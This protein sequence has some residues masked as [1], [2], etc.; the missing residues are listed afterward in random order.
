MNKNKIIALL[1]S[2]AMVATMTGTASTLAYNRNKHNNN[3]KN[4]V[5]LMNHAQTESTGYACVVNGNNNLVLTNSKGNIT[6]YLS[7][8]EMLHI[9]SVTGNKVYV[10]VKETG[11]KGYINSSNILNI[12]NANTSNITRMNRKG[13]IVNVSSTV[14]LRKGPGMD[15][16]VQDGLINNT[17]IRITGKV[18]QW[19]RV[20][21]NGQKGYIFE[22]YVAQA[23]QPS[24]P[25]INHAEI[26]PNQPLSQINP[27]NVGIISK[28]NNG[29]PN[30]TS[31]H[32]QS[33]PVIN[34][35]ELQPNVQGKP[36]TNHGELQ[37][38]VQ[39]KPV[40]NHGEL[41]P[42]VQGK[43]VTNHGELQPNVPANPITNHGELQPQQPSSQVNPNNGG[44][45]Q[46]P[47][48]GTTPNTVPNQQ[49]TPITNHSELQPQQPSSQVNPNNGGTITNNGNQ[50]PT[51]APAPAKKGKI[52]NTHGDT[53]GPNTHGPTVPSNPT[54]AVTGNNGG[55]TS[56]PTPS[57]GQHREQPNKVIPGNPESTGG[58]QGPT[59]VH[60]GTV[61]GG[62]KV[63]KPAHQVPNTPAPTPNK[64]TEHN[65]PNTGSNPNKGTTPAPT[66]N[67]GSNP[68]K[69]SEP[70]TPTTPNK[71][72]TP[73]T[74]KPSHEVPAVS[75][76][77]LVAHNVRIVLGHNFTT[78]MIS[79]STNDGAQ[80]TYKGV[81]NVNTT[82]PGKYPVE[83]IATKDGV[84]T[85]VNVIIT[86]VDEAPSLS[87][88]NITLTQGTPFNDSL[89]NIRAVSVT[90][91]NLDSSVK[92]AGNVDVN[93]P[94][95]YNLT[96]SVTDQYGMTSTL[97]VTV[98]VKA[99][100]E[101]PNKPTTPV[102]TPHK[103]TN[104]NNGHNSLANPILPLPV[105]H[106]GHNLVITEGSNFTP[107]MIGVSATEK[108]E[109]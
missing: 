25:I 64:G 53:T 62:G 79:A 38:N 57:K 37:P 67:T 109:P 21:V 94:G 14:N 13:Y 98:T 95:T 96:L 12:N 30:S 102:P 83:V 9:E 33:S 29:I 43:P 45:E 91:Y 32:I 15:T 89:L 6:S 104:K 100:P 11:A 80:I 66:P 3:V 10:T 40:T 44:T 46:S 93:K 8:G 97:Q 56:T 4:E 99:N 49:G 24:V 90:G 1:V 70:N 78:S 7:V 47:N 41:Q 74:V 55:K 65:T 2:G 72:T 28:G 59:H 81:E 84:S 52:V 34:H 76:P 50:T 58:Q 48:K 61:Q 54:P 82:K 105:F 69:G 39:G 68:N 101:V 51:P 103:N 18:G 5:L 22:E 92:V 71:G 35:G 86:V 17:A 85:H 42:N 73:N 75:T 31:K 87:A 77:K 36:V 16:N 107:S 88:R 63:I 60:D 108:G 106:G 19:Y 20:S 26:Q 23:N 27:S